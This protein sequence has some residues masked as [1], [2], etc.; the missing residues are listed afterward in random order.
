[1]LFNNIFPSILFTKSYPKPLKMRYFH[2]IIH[3]LFIYKQKFFVSRILSMIRCHHAS[4]PLGPEWFKHN[5]LRILVLSSLMKNCFI[6]IKVAQYLY[7]LLWISVPKLLKFSITE[8]IL[9]CYLSN[10]LT[11]ILFEVNFLKESLLL[12][13]MV[14]II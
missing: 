3:R 2:R 10:I 6:F 7:L 5:I 8:N 12:L 4:I 14:M 9:Y 1:M 11:Y 13:L